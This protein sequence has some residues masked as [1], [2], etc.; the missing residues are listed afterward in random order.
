MISCTIDSMIHSLVIPALDFT[1][2]FLLTL[3]CRLLFPFAASA[4]IAKLLKIY[5]SVV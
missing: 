3:I 4:A 5:S 1:E 2:G